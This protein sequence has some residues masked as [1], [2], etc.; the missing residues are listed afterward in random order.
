MGGYEQNVRTEYIKMPPT[1]KRRD[2]VIDTD[3]VEVFTK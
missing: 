3:E 1:K 2:P